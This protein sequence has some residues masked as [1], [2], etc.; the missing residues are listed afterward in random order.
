MTALRW[1]AAVVLAVAVAVL[2][3][4]TPAAAHGPAS[5][6]VKVSLAEPSTES[7]GP[8]VRVVATVALQQLDI[9]YGTTLMDEASRTSAD[10][11]V[12]AHA[13]ELSEL[14][15]DRVTLTGVD[16]ASWTIVVD[17]VSGARDEGQDAVRVVLLARGP[18]GGDTSTV[19]LTWQVVTDVVVTH[20][21]YV[22]GVSA[23]GTTTLVDTLTR[24]H[25]T[26]TLTLDDPGAES[27]LTPRW[28]GAGLLLLLSGLALR[29]RRQPAGRPA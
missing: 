16:D 1:V 14:F 18:A 26:T 19:D 22:G 20:D 23:D 9:A 15:L 2:A 6:L 3:T 28:A 4:A 13:D 21:V 27:R 24:D 8:E 10:D 7:S 11:T 25:Q 5:T 12:A 17:S 29:V